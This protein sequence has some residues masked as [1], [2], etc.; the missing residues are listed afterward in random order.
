M[1]SKQ[2]VELAREKLSASG[3][4]L[5]DAKQLGMIIADAAEVQQLGHKDTRPG[6]VFAYYDP[7]AGSFTAPT[8]FHRVRFLG[9]LTGFAA[10]TKPRRY[11]QPAGTLNS[12]YIPRVKGINWGVLLAGSEPLVITEGELKAACACKLGIPTIGLGGVDLI[13]A[14]KKGADAL[15][16]LDQIHWAGR[17][18]YVVFDTDQPDGLK[19][20]VRQSAGRLMDFL[21]ARG[22]VPMLATLPAEEDGSKVGL[23]DFLVKH[24]AERFSDEVLPTALGHNSAKVLCDLAADYCYIESM[25]KFMGSDPDVAMSAAHFD[26]VAKMRK[27]SLLA[28]ERHRVE[29]G[30]ITKMTPQVMSPSEALVTWSGARRYTNVIYAPGS[31]SVVL[32]GG[33]SYANLWG[34][35]R[36]EYTKDTL[37]SEAQRNKVMSE[38]FW[39]MDNVF[40]EDPTAREFAEHW[41]FY[42]IQNPGAKLFTCMIVC[43]LLQGV[44]KSFLGEMLAK[45]VYGA[46]KPGPT[47]AWV[48]TEGDLNT[49]FN[50]YMH[51]RSFVMGDDIASHDRKAVYEKVKSYVTSPIVQINT[52]NVPQYMSDNCTNFYLTGNELAMFYLQDN[53]RRSMVHIIRR[54]TKAV[55]R[56]T[57]LRK[58]FDAGIGGPT[59]LWYARE[60]YDAKAFNPNAAAPVTASKRE[61][62]GYSKQGVAEWVADLVS[63]LE[64]VSR[65]FATSEEVLALLELAAPHLAQQRG[66]VDR[67]GA[68]LRENG[69]Q[70]W[71]GGKQVRI[72]VNG[73]HKR[74]RVWV[75]GKFNEVGEMGENHIKTA[76]EDTP[77]QF[78]EVGSKVTPIRK[79][80]K[81]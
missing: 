50:S 39:A 54:P 65:P 15:P 37:P 29:G 33:E 19:D 20:S 26:R 8:I 3:L 1:P 49:P 70:Q 71:K 40:G 11:G 78:I 76:I 12:V 63:D 44:G 21:L 45:H 10:Q 35:W 55:E 36:S 64:G 51:A 47:H 46:V 79:A 48:L 16:L 4:T 9:D 80:R 6:I 24:G 42:P 25:D 59:L 43:S 32:R 7:F 2:A 14:Q 72:L 62:I 31:P 18:V 57:E 34:G 77:F 38:W 58:L 41:F 81:Y 27:V 13:R 74:S 22:A 30:Y 60:K 5:E 67:I 53:D 61:V 52:K 17:T 28:L 73:M 23:D 56:Y 66:T 75:L 68:F 69:A